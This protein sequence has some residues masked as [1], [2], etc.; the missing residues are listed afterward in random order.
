LCASSLSRTFWLARRV[1]LTGITLMICV[2]KAVVEIAGKN[3]IDLAVK[4]INA[5]IAGEP[6]F[7]EN[8]NFKAR[9]L[10]T[11]FDDRPGAL[12]LLDY[13]LKQDPKIFPEEVTVNRAAQKKARALWEQITGKEYP[14]L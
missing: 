5:A 13:V 3:D 6:R 10:W 14:P 4:L 7:L 12:K 1:R 8:Y 9:L 11:Y 2:P